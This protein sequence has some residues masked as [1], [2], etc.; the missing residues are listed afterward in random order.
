MRSVPRL[1][2][3]LNLMLVECYSH[4][5]ADEQRLDALRQ[6][7]EGDRALES[8]RIE[9]GRALARAGKL[10]EAVA[11][12]SPL[13]ERKPEIR[14]DLV[15]ILIQ[16]ASRAPRDPRTWQ[17]V[18]RHLREAEKALPQSVEPLT[19]LKVDMLAA[20]DRLEDARSL[21]ASAQAKDPRNLQYRLA[22]A[23]LTQRQGK[24]PSALQILDQA[25]Q[26]LGPSLGIQ[27][28]RLDYWGH[29][30]G[31]GGQGRGGQAGRDS[32]ANPRRRPARVSRPAGRDRDPAPR[33]WPWR[34]NTGASWRRSSRIT[35]V[36]GSVC[37]TWPSKPVTRTPPP[38]S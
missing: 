23:R 10:D 31:R 25:E 26:D 34:D 17:D 22:L 30:R 19:L 3:P 2:A 24:G 27:L 36:S 35:S 38:I 16:K 18:E 29:A 37:S 28:A 15:S 8:T 21:L 6:A 7:A 11:V 33:N 20:R 32:A 13:A 14:L 4:V 1:A 5:G 12:L 9:F